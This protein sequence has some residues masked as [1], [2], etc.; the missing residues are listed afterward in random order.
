MV[1]CLSLGMRENGGGQERKDVLSF[2][3][4]M[5]KGKRS[6]IAINY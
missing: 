6:S 2:N 1:C 4:G 3:L 5:R